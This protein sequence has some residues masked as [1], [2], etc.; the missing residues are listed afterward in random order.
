M[1]FSVSSGL[2][3]VPFNSAA[4]PPTTSQGSIDASVLQ[5]YILDGNWASN[6]T[7]GIQ[8]TSVGIL[9]QPPL[10]SLLQKA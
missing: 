5:K 8:N 7:I 10:I 4:A 2:T 9:I 6:N 1:G 3:Y